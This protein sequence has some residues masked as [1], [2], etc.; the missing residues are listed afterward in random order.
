MKI[1]IAAVSIVVTLGLAGS[2]GVF[3]VASTNAA[4][5][6]KIDHLNDQSGTHV[7]RN[8]LDL[9]LK[10]WEQSQQQVVKVLEEIKEGL[11]DARD[12]SN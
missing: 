4:Q 12:N 11:R 3:Y 7:T 10:L 5:D 9:S 2:G 1:V 8:E 6:V